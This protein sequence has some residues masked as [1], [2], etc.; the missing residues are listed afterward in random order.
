MERR[1]T[2]R[3]ACPSGRG[4]H[5]PAP[6]G[7]APRLDGRAPVRVDEDRPL[8]SASPRRTPE[9]RIVHHGLPDPRGLRRRPRGLRPGE[10]D[11]LQRRP[12][13]LPPQ[14]PRN[15][16]ACRAPCAGSASGLRRGRYL[17]RRVQGRHALLLLDACRLFP[18]C[19]RVSGRAF[20]RRRAAEAED[21]GARR[22]PQPHRPGHR[23]RLLLLPRRVRAAE[24]GLRGH[25]GELEPGDGLDGLRYIRPPLLR[26]AHARRRDGDLR[27]R[28]LRRRDRAVRRADPAQPCAE[29]A[30]G[31]RARDRH[32]AGRHRPRRGP[33]R[34]QEARRRGRHAPAAERHRAHGRR[35][36]AG[37]ERDRLPRPR[38]PELRPGRTRHGDRL[39]GEVPRQV[40]GGGGARR[41]GQAHPHRQVPRTRDRAGRRLRRGRRDDGRRRH[42]RPRRAGR[43]PSR[44]RRTATRRS[45]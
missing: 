44:R 35:G 10:G 20:P 22:R 3:C 4:P 9:I 26:T 43:S 41:R 8:V 36:R 28:T 38:A 5:L 31:G 30:R 2:R 27:P 21:H 37:G 25:H 39:Q 13:R 11:G 19:L 6:R 29:A 23:V 45:G 1:R 7:P 16:G 40:R 42:P 34:L 24:A 33:R 32:V 12:D 14:G 15:G 17:R 18:P